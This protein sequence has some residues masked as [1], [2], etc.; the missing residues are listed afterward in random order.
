MLCRLQY[1]RLLFSGFLLIH[2]VFLAAQPS[3]LRF[4]RLNVEEGFVNAGIT[5]IF[6]DSRGFMWLGGLAGLTRYDG[7]D[8]VS[9]V[10]DPTDSL[11]IGD[12][13][14]NVI[15]ESRSGGLWVGA[16]NGLN[17]FDPE[18]ETFTRF[19]KEVDSH[20]K[21]VLGLCEDNSGK[22]W[23]VT[24][25]G[26]YILDPHTRATKKLNAPNE[27]EWYRCI[28]KGKDG[29]I[30]AG[31]TKGLY[32]A[33][34]TDRGIQMLP[35]PI[36]LLKA[37]YPHNINIHIIAEN[38][39]GELWLGARNG[40]IRYNP[41]VGEAT[42]ISFGEDSSF[43]VYTIRI[44]R[45]GL[46]WCATT[47]GL[48]RIDP[49][50]L[51]WRR[52]LS[53][54]N[55]N[56]SLIS[57]S[58]YDI[59]ED[60]SGIIWISTTGG[61]NLFKPFTENFRGFPNDYQYEMGGVARLR[62]FFEI[63]PG[64]L[65]LWE[66]GQLMI[67]DWQRGTKT[68]FPYSPAGNPE[69]WHSRFFCF[70]R[71]NKDRIW[72]GTEGGVFVFDST[73][74]QFTHYHRDAAPPFALS[75][76]F[77]RDIYQDHTGA[78]W[79]TTWSGGTNCIDAETGE[80]S[81][82]LD[83]SMKDLQTHGRTIFEDRNGTVWIGTRGGLFKYDRENKQFIRY[84]HDPG[85]PK[86]MSEN[87]AFDIYEDEYGCLWIG[88]FGGGLNMFDPYLETFTHYTVKDG[89]PDN[90][91]LS[92]LPDGKGNLWMSTFKSI[93][94]FDPDKKTFTSFDHKDGLL[95][96]LFSAFSHYQSPYSGHLIY[97]GTEGIDI[98]HPDSLEMDSVP[99]VV[100]ITDLQLFNRSVPIRRGAEEAKNGDFY[101][102][103]SIT[104]TKELTL[105]YRMKVVTLKFAALHFANP[106][107]N[108]YAYM[109]EGFDEAWQD[110]G[111]RRTATFTNLPPGKYRFRVKAYNA[112]GIESEKEA[113]LNLIIQPPWWLTWWAY[114]FYI[115][116][117]LAVF[118]GYLSYQRQRW[119][120]QSELEAQQREAR[121]L[122]ELDSFKSRLYANITHEFRTPLTVIMGLTEE[123]PAY[124]QKEET[125][126]LQQAVELVRRNSARVLQLINQMLGLARI[127]AG[128]MAVDMMQGDVIAFLKYLTESHESLA[129]AKN[130]ALSFEAAPSQ[131]VMDYDEEKLY[132][133]FSNL[134][135][136]AI[137]FT[138]EGG[139]VSIR[140]SISETPAGKFL[141]LEVSDTGIG[142]PED[143]LNRIFERFYQVQ[144]PPSP[145]EGGGLGRAGLLPPPRGGWGGLGL[146]LEPASA[147]PSSKSWWSCSG[148]KL[149]SKA[150]QAAAPGSQCNCPS[151]M[152]RL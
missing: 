91:V 62:S 40:V 16:Q 86:S 82:V 139:K 109:L 131:L 140:I 106:A 7:Y 110:I 13:K 48:F 143:Q 12:H 144:A 57:N 98:F 94:K 121:R 135:S 69:A 107:K 9:Y 38:A 138:G 124:H 96:Q 112:Y 61:I 76:N 108:K 60:R 148:E 133:I 6:Q 105:P 99:P 53:I 58:I 11:S 1:S 42:Y 115:L 30:W 101:L 4:E 87:T 17:Y 39:A 32:K 151:A 44:D 72:M 77:I 33:R 71:D 18:K 117:T 75:S 114:L 24:P 118:Y 142:I 74:N 20:A 3:N 141:V 130:I 83:D 116:A 2:A 102:S 29:A 146:E 137:K 70:F 35:V 31:T 149:K 67:F 66:D 5:A 27:N 26:I 85:D 119:R 79:V 73:S 125:S 54:R 150:N 56:N 55:D 103:Q 68:P 14:A 92:I 122:Q 15:I 127:E 145:P 37:S 90:N 126:R 52:F 47:R 97:E 80:V 50:T 132:D 25:L 23:T 22:I 129:A 128:M 104:E 45:N 28:H 89:L 19:L 136:N 49:K 123:I 134:V 120:A 152:M 51:G 36:N 59:Y 41:T 84:H 111:N 21:S 113:S 95:N 78:V 93:V 100:Q 63:S 81:L 64:K 43:Y 8:A 147:L 46:V 88:T 34:E 10:Y 65:L